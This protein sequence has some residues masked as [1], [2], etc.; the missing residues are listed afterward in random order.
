[1]TPL[2]EIQQ[3]VYDYTRDT[4]SAGLPFPSLREIAAHFGFQHTTA[5]FHLKALEKKGYIRQR[6]Q[7]VSEYLL[8]DAA[9][10]DLPVHD[11][12][13][14]ERGFDLVAKIPAGAPLPV[15]DETRERFDVSQDFFGGGEIIGIRVVGD[16]MS[17]DAIAD[18]DIAMIKRQ[19]EANKNDVLALRIEDEITLKRLRLCGDRAEL[20]PSNP[21]HDIRSVPADRVEIIG[22]LVGIVRKV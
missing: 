4:L 17:G 13:R 20:L 7:R 16:S 12:E 8:N 9:T 22:K 11:H 19:R 6:A 5:R 1:M 10:N 2:T 14:A 21:L 15:F 3:A 18:G